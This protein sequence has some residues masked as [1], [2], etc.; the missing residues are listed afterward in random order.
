[1]RLMRLGRAL[2]QPRPARDL[3]DQC[4]LCRIRQFFE[5]RFGKSLLHV[6][7]I[8][9]AGSQLRDP[10]GVIDGSGSFGTEFSRRVSH[11]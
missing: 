8:K 1:M 5:W 3:T 2:D 4:D 10:N 7:I 9:V 6:R 11:Y